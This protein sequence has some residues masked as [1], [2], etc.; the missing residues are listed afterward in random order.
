MFSYLKIIKIIVI[1]AI[2]RGEHLTGVQVAALINKNQKL[3][4]NVIYC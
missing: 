3:P 2:Q 1:A 4:E